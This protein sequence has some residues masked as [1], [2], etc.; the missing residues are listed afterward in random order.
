MVYFSFC[1]WYSST[2]MQKHT[3]C[4]HCQLECF[5]CFPPFLTPTPMTLCVLLGGS[6]LILVLYRFTLTIGNWDYHNDKEVDFSFDVLIQW[7]KSKLKCQYPKWKKTRVFRY[8]ISGKNI[9][10]LET[11]GKT[12][13]GSPSSSRTSC[14][15]SESKWSS[16][17]D[18]NCNICRGWKK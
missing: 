10:T 5:T 11:L 1:G 13:L 15:I 9:G 17:S 12:S 8:I 2:V 18:R 16:L 3:C 4:W 14:W 7:N 6:R